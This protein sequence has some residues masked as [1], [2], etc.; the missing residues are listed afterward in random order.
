MVQSGSPE[1]GVHKTEH[2]TSSTIKQTSARSLMFVCWSS[3]NARRKCFF[4]T[5]TTIS[6]CTLVCTAR[7]CFGNRRNPSWDVTRAWNAVKTSADQQQ[8]ATQAGLSD[9]R[10][11]HTTRLVWG[12]V[13]VLQNICID[14]IDV[15][16]LLLLSSASTPV[17]KVWMVLWGPADTA[18]NNVPLARR[19]RSKN[20]RRRVGR[21]KRS[22]FV[23][24]LEKRIFC[25]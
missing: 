3:N 21:F 10:D 13:C 15:G 23:A 7:R 14:L 25:R 1:P 8:S 12:P 16:L 11:L 19:S 2:T 6:I 24:N 4:A 5:K 9:N 17:A 22:L 20:D 18:R